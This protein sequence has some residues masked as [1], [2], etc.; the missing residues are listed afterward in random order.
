MALAG[1]RDETPYVNHQQVQQDVEAL[2]RAGAGKIGTVGAVL[3]C[4][5]Q[6]SCCSWIA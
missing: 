2:Y 4:A 6:Y 5:S 3:I 1:Q